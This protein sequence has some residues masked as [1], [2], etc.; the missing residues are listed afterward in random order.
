MRSDLERISDIIEAIE[1]IE[2]KTL[3][4]R[5]LFN[6]DEMIQVWVIHHL[7]II[8]EAVR[9]MS[10]EFLSLHPDI[11]W[12]DIIGMRNILVHHYF[13]IDKEAVWKVIELDLPIIKERLRTFI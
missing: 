12:S 13:G 4:R 11:P 3:N 10:Q 8:G 6:N 5:N 2:K 7:L 9:A 1:Q